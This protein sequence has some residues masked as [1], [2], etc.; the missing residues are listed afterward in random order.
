M[1]ENNSP[2]PESN[3]K[4]KEQKAADSFVSF[5]EAIK[6]KRIAISNAASGV[7]KSLK[8]ILALEKRSATHFD[9]I[10]TNSETGATT[11]KTTLDNLANTTKTAISNSLE[12]V[13]KDR[14]ET[15]DSYINFKK[16]Y[17]AAMDGSKGIAARKRNV[18]VHHERVTALHT[19]IKDLSERSKAHATEV[20]VARDASVLDAAIVKSVKDRSEEVKKE[21]E[22]TFQL[23]IDTALGGSL[24]ARK[25]EILKIMR[26]WAVALGV[27][28]VALLAV[29]SFLLYE[30]RA[31]LAEAV[32]TRLVYVTPL[33]FVVFLIYRQYSHERHLL[34]EYAFKSAMAQTLRNYTVLLSETY[35]GNEAERKTLDFLL[36]AMTSIYDRSALDHNTGFFYQLIIGSRKAGAELTVQDGTTD[37]KQTASQKVKLTNSTKLETK[38]NS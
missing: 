23:T 2:I 22:N 3:L 34:E 24:G 16:T 36:K 15:H 7:A 28:V 21:I 37:I 5:H 20:K 31:N 6:D 30:G 33:L 19:N 9:K 25:G 18:E 12:E 1:A 27:A 29:I 4:A 8:A 14:K 10:R 13:E 38:Q 26:A 35:K 17:K 32:A 11:L